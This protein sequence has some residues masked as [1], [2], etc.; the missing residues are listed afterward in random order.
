M[1][2]EWA[3]QPAAD[4][5][6]IPGK[7]LAAAREAMGWSVEQIADQLKMAVRQVIAL[8][9]GDYAALPGPAVVRGFV[10]AYAKVVRLDPGPLVAQIALDAPEAGISGSIRRDARPASFSQ[11]RYP[12]HGRRSKL[13]VVPILVA[14]LVAAAGVAAWQFGLIPASLTGSTPAADSSVVTETVPMTSPSEPVLQDPSVPLISVPPPPAASG[15]APAAP[16]AGVTGPVQG[17][18]TPAAAAPATATPPAAVPAP[19]AAGG[20][21]ALVVDVREDSWVEVRDAKGKALMRRMVK[22]GETANVDIAGPSTLIVGKPG[23][24][25][26]TLRGAPVAL[27]PMQGSTISRVKVQ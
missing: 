10:R 22:A 21:N 27:P 18:G 2:G 24:V 12:S 13:P 5:H 16:A 15:T 23:A 9:A 3:D 26:A 14:V 20:A 25:T 7:T 11:S 8:E 17:V 6:G 19:A 1:S 4:N